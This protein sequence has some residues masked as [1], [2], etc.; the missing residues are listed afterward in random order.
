MKRPHSNSN[1]NSS[2]DCDGCDDSQSLILHVA[3]IPEA[4]T[5]EDVEAIFAPYGPL[6]EAF[7][8]GVSAAKKTRFAFVT[9]ASPAKF[10][11]AL[12]D[13]TERPPML[14]GYRLFVS[15]SKAAPLRCSECG[16]IVKRAELEWHKAL[17]HTLRAQALKRR[18]PNE[19]SGE[20]S[21][22]CAGDGA[23]P[24]YS[25]AATASVSP[26]V[27]ERLRFD[28]PELAARARAIET[29]ERTIRE[30]WPG[31]KVVP[32]G[33][34]AVGLAGPEDDIDVSLQV[35]L[36]DSATGQAWA[37]RGVLCA[38]KKRLI[39]TLPL[40]AGFMRLALDARVPV[41]SYRP[42]PGAGTCEEGE[43][44][45]EEKAQEAVSED[46]R[47]LRRTKFDLC[48]NRTLGVLN[49]RL[50][51]DYVLCRPAVVRPFLGAVRA[52]S[53]AWGINNSKGGLLNSYAVTLMGVSFLQG[54]GVLPNLQRGVDVIDK[55]A[56]GADGK[57]LLKGDIAKEGLACYWLQQSAVS[58]DGKER[59]EEGEKEKEEEEEGRD[60][61]GGE[62]PNFMD[63]FMGF[64]AHYG[65]DFEFHSTA[66]SVRE[67]GGT[68]L[69]DSLSWDAPATERGT[70]SG[71]CIVDPFETSFNVA[72]H[73][74]FQRAEE[75]ASTFRIAHSMISCEL[76][77]ERVDPCAVADLMFKRPAL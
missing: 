69:R 15:R 39:G 66:V 9:L 27:L 25:S 13:L 40:R 23:G 30:F 47:N 63:L 71:V 7:L 44:E 24:R 62:E 16:A 42:E 12:A 34:Y 76:A 1:S 5:K 58:R 35:D 11:A 45:K 38:L 32:F 31:A 73:V 22:A 19:G 29:L 49:S 8:S 60:E 48:V 55:K 36:R 56:K 3:N 18:R 64:L 52:W 51:K 53:R 37:E 10:S 70:R 46:V 59:E 43:E 20:G 4:G 26:C 41:L 77:K 33:S 50:L 74:S 17:I 65:W 72:R 68:A 67:D 75:I 14:R 54:R 61:R 2:D 28:S 21:A 57:R 6:E